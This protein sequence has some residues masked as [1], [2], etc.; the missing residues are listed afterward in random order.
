MLC[1]VMLCYIYI[2]NPQKSSVAEWLE[3]S[4]PDKEVPS[5]TPGGSQFD[6]IAK[7]LCKRAFGILLQAYWQ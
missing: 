1:N 6:S 4:P 5:S 2:Y 3:R 7:I